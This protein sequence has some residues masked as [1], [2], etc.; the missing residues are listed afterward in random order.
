MLSQW[1]ASMVH[2]MKLEGSF[3]STFP[4]YNRVA[5]NINAGMALFASQLLRYQVPTTLDPHSSSYIGLA[6]YRACIYIVA[7]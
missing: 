5:V 7:S 1:V 3:F 4:I 2:K 6:R